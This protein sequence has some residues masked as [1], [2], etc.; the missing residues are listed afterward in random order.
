MFISY[1]ASAA[2]GFKKWSAAHP[3]AKYARQSNKAAPI[4][5]T[6]SDTSLRD[7]GS[8]SR[9]MTNLKHPAIDVRRAT[10]LRETAEGAAAGSPLRERLLDLAGQYDRMA[11]NARHDSP[12]A[13]QMRDE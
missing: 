2:N 12:E 10:R 9:P 11:A 13:R 1:A 8:T 5:P 6:I 4:V 7:A 3:V